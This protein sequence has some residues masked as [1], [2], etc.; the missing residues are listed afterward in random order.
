MQ[1]QEQ[2][3]SSLSLVR[4]CR[5]SSAASF[6]QKSHSLGVSIPLPL[7]FL[8]SPRGCEL[9]AYCRALLLGRAFP[10]GRCGT[11]SRR[12]SVLVIDP[13]PSLLSQG[14]GCRVLFP[15][16]SLSTIHPVVHIPIKCIR[17]IACVRS[18]IREL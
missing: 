17:A 8:R 9:F 14:D 3:S 18:Y 1:D 6:P 16:H 11:R 7:S 4:I 2:K 13:F 5:G 15:L 10:P 12:S